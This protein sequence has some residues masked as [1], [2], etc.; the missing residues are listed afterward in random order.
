[1]V[2]FLL[3]FGLAAFVAGALYGHRLEVA[4]VGG[5]YRVARKYALALIKRSE[6]FVTRLDKHL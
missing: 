6:D 2:L 5:L 3:L 1:M 4:F